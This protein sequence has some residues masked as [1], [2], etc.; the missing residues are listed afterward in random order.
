MH[1][2]LF[3]PFTLTLLLPLSTAT[4]YVPPGADTSPAPCTRCVPYPNALGQCHITTSCIPVAGASTQQGAPTDGVAATYCA[5]RAGFRA[6]G[7][8]ADN[9]TAQYR[10]PWPGQEYRVFVAPGVECN[11]ECEHPEYGPVESCREVPERRE[12]Y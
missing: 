11:T 3:L 4:T 5:C 1:I 7:P 2:S 6:T 8:A 10:L 12:C 9:A